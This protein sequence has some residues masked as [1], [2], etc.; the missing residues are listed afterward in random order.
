M[1]VVFASIYSCKKTINFD[2]CLKIRNEKQK[3]YKTLYWKP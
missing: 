1:N 3:L 2:I